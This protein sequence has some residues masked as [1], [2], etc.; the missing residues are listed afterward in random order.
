VRRH[1]HSA[2][3]STVKHFAQCRVCVHYHRYLAD[4]AAHG[5]AVSTL[6]NQVSSVDS[7]DVDSQNL[8]CLFVVYHLGDSVSLV[9][10]KGLA[11]R[12]EVTN[13]FSNLETLLLALSFSLILTETNESDFRMCEASCGYRIVVYDMR[14]AYDILDGGNSLVK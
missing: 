6:L 10:C 9:L 2:L 11:V 3:E 14:S 13:T 8:L 7:D 1:A 12:S 5:N 4:G